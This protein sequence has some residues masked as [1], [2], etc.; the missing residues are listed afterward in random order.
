[1]NC[2]DNFVSK[3]NEIQIGWTGKW[4]TLFAYLFSYMASYIC[5]K[6]YFMF[7][8]ADGISKMSPSRYILHGKLRT[9]KSRKNNQSS[10]ASSPPPQMSTAEKQDI[11][12]LFLA[13]HC[14]AL[15]LDRLIL[16]YERTFFPW[17]YIVTMMFLYLCINF[18]MC[19]RSYVQ[20]FNNKLF[21]LSFL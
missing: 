3:A 8:L 11:F 17:H 9:N 21:F 2:L 20:W 19:I 4:Y 16:F 18:Y 1:M 14:A 5:I 15:Q 10:E 6:Q 7:T 12:D 13:R